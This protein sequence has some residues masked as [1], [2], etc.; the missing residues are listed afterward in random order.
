MT[1][2]AMD[3]DLFFFLCGFCAR[4]NWRFVA[5]HISTEGAMRLLPPNH[6]K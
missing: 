5:D 3:R 2:G 1:E 4:P 6:G